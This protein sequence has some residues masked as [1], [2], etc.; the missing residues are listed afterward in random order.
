MTDDLDSSVPAAT[1]SKGAGVK[2]SPAR[3]S[4]GTRRNV[5]ASGQEMKPICPD[6]I[7]L[8]ARRLMPR[9]GGSST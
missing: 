7:P 9:L 5:P 1:P 6:E 2:V 3:Y 4:P 8:L